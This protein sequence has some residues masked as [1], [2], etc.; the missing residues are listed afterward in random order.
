MAVWE[1]LE[2]WVCQA[3]KARPELSVCRVQS[4]HEEVLELLVSMETEVKY[5]CAVYEKG[6][7][8]RL[9]LYLSL[10]IRAG[11][12]AGLEGCN[13]LESQPLPTGWKILQPSTVMTIFGRL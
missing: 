7:R 8:I 11:S 12:R 10:L 13:R 9:S 3:T 5:G 6:N 2:P 4:G 1:T